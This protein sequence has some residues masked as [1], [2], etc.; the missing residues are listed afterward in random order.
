MKKFKVLLTLLAIAV[1]MYACRKN[2]EPQP[3]KISFKTPANFPA[4]IYQ[5]ENNTLTNEGFALGKKLFYDSRL[6]ADKSVSCGSC[7]QQFAAFANIDHPVSHGVNN[8]LGKR[9]APVLFNLAWQK[10]FFL[11]GGAKNLEIT[12]LNAINDACEMATN[13]NDVLEFL[14]STAPYPQLFKAAFGNDNITSQNFLRALAQFMATMV[15]ANSKY[16]K[17]MLN[18]QANAF[19]EEELKGYQLFKE[20]C[21]KCHSEPLFTNLTY[22]N[23]GLDIDSD[24]EG[25]K[26]ITGLTSDAGKFKIP[27]LRNITLS[28]PYMHDGRFGTLTQVLEHYNNGVKNTSNLAAELNKNAKL[29]IALTTS[30]KQQLISFLKTLTDDEF[31]Q[32]KIFSEN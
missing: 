18:P 14:K 22:A 7:H 8:C 25:R 13:L 10:E 29:G 28:A 12:P 4:A 26:K 3:E 5:F 21:S 27:T 23:T 11:D 24:D 1:L 17:V 2:D 19:T 15:S 20:K 31:I 9:N 16:D 32:N 6:S 30:E